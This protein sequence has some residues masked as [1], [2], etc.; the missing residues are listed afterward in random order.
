MAKCSPSKGG[1]WYCGDDS[2]PLV[3]SYEFDTFVHIDCIYDWGV[4]LLNSPDGFDPEWEILAKEF[5]IQIDPG[6]D[7]ATP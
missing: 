1:C 2:P 3:F 5:G 6:L 4:Y 7:T